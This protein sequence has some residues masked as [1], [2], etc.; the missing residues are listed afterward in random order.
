MEICILDR[1]SF[2]LYHLSDFFDNDFILATPCAAE[3]RSTSSVREH[4][5]SEIPDWRSPY[6]TQDFGVLPPVSPT[7]GTAE[8]QHGAFLLNV[9]QIILKPLP[10]KRF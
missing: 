4:P 9:S 6:I 5:R 8:H 2:D 7:P 1:R 10:Q 3:A